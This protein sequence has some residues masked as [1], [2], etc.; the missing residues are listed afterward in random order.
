M[1]SLAWCCGFI[2]LFPISSLLLPK[3][4]WGGDYCPAALLGILHGGNSRKDEEIHHHLWHAARALKEG[5][6]LLIKPRRSMC[7]K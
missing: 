1:E 3:S 7:V 6:V 2:V 4:I 5:G